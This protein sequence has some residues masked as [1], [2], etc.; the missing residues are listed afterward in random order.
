MSLI[1]KKGTLVRRGTIFFNN[2]GKR[3]LAVR[4]DSPKTKEACLA[5]GYDI[6]VF[7]LKTLE[8]FGGIGITEKVQKMRYDH[9]LKKTENAL[10]EIAIQR[11]NIIKKNKQLINI[12]IEKGHQKDSEIMNEM[13][14]T[15]QRKMADIYVDEDEESYLSYDEEDPIIVLENKL[16]K[17]IR[18]YHKALAVKSKEIQNQ[19]MNEQRRYN[20]QKDLERR[21]QKI[22]MLQT[23]LLEEK[24]KKKKKM[25]MEAMIKMQKIREKEQEEKK[26]QDELRKLQYEKLEKLRQKLKEEEEKKKIEM[27]EHERREQEKLQKVLQQKSQVDFYQERKMAKTL[28]EIQFGFSRAQTQQQNLLSTKSQQISLRLL[29]NENRIQK[30]KTQ[31]QER[32]QHSV[33]LLINKMVSKEQELKNLQLEKLR[34]DALKLREERLKRKK[35]SESLKNLG[36]QQQQKQSQL[37]GKFSLMD[38]NNQKRQQELEYQRNLKLEKTRLKKLDLEENYNR[39]ERMKDFKFRQIIKDSLMHNELQGIEKLQNELV[40]KARQELQRKLKQQNET[41]DGSLLNITQGENSRN[42]T[43][44]MNQI[45][46]NIKHYTTSK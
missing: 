32:Q 9:Y 34:Q 35:I 25:K 39:Q 23:K 13:V 44:I 4:P 2:N 38:S 46:K 5:L 15:Y 37:K 28:S 41:L 19:I 3:S 22:K 18:K 42:M 29:S 14:E 33:S 6:S 17:Q 10:K 12:Q 16:D 21:E 11:K 26:K 45:D 20:M 36:Q 40:M 27:Q 31:S 8:E 24:L 30:L 43:M 7:K 1:I